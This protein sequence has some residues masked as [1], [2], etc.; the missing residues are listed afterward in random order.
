VVGTECPAAPTCG[1]ESSCGGATACGGN[2]ACTGEPEASGGSGP[3]SS[4][5]EEAST[6]PCGLAFCVDGPTGG[7]GVPASGRAPLPDPPSV[8]LAVL[9]AA[10]EVPEAPPRSGWTLDT[11]DDFPASPTRASFHQARA[12]PTGA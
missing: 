9:I 10:L 2:A 4:A 8:A 1:G 3:L 6:F 5:C 12:P 11:G 7:D